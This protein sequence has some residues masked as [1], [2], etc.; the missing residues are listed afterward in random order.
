M[1]V[2]L[3]RRLLLLFILF[4]VGLFIALPDYQTFKLNTPWWSG[5]LSLGIPNWSTTWFGRQWTLPRWPIKQG[6]DIQGGI[7]VVLRADMTKIDSLDRENALSSARD[8]ILRRVDMYGINEPVVRSAKQG[9]DYRIIVELP[10][11]DKPEE[12]LALVGRTAQLQFL[13]LQS[14]ATPSAS[15]TSSGQLGVNL[16]ETGLDGSLLRR[17]AVQFDQKTGEPIV[18]LEFNT[19][20]AKLFGDITSQNIGQPLGIF[21]DGSPLMAPVISTPILD[22]QAVITGDFGLDEAKQLSIQLNAGALPVP[23]QILEQKTVEASLGSQAVQRSAV[24]GV[25]GLVLVIAFMVIYYGKKGIIAGLALILY[26]VLTFAAYKLLGVTLT[27]PGIAGLLLTI[28][29]AVDANI[30]IFE[31]MK[32]EERAG[33]TPVQAL[34]LGFGRAWDSIKDANTA[35]ILTALVLINPLNFSFLNTSGLVRGFGLTLL[36]G[37]LLSLF[38]GVFV[39]RTLMQLTYGIYQKVKR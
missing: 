27:V 6:L 35:T 14:S 38:T 2:S 24:A 13:L 11:V 18:S 31:R 21:L 3:K 34:E 16:V 15:A 26:A 4:L 29:M 28:G 7:Q 19:D 25:I 22:G 5:Q 20:G 23:I 36:I 10:G 33:R 30:L 39:S 1:L 8:V 37:V 12:A 32:E 17:S 9:E